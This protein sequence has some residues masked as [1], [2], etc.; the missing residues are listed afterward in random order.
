ME[1]YN[2]MSGRGTDSV[3]R[4]HTILVAEDIDS[5]FALVD[6]ILRKDFTIVRATNG[7]DAIQ[8]FK[9]VR[10]SL[11]LMDIQMPEL[12]GLEATRII[13]DLDE[14]IPIVALTAF[15][16]NSDRNEFLQA[17]GS[18]YIVKPIDPMHLRDKIKRMLE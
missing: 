1:D 6:I 5:N 4:K 12:N 14:H 16:F 15:A 8:L 11:I 2:N 7:N 18:D 10:P 13:R 9:D 17:G 3:E